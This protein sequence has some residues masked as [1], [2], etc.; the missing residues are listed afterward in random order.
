MIEQKWPC[1]HE[2]II[3]R[4]FGTSSHQQFDGGA[5]DE[6]VRCDART[7]VVMTMMLLSWCLPHKA[8]HS[9][10]PHNKGCF[11]PGTRPLPFWPGDVQLG[12]YKCMLSSNNEGNTCVAMVTC[13][14]STCLWVCEEHGLH[15]IAVRRRGSGMSVELV[16][17]SC[18]PGWPGESKPRK[19]IVK[20]VW[21]SGHMSCARLFALWTRGSHHKPEGRREMDCGDSQNTRARQARTQC[22]IKQNP[23]I[24][25][26]LI[27]FKDTTLCCHHILPYI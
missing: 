20:K 21:T 2:K 16:H 3:D 24:T 7:F 4:W 15:S 12:K 11:L 9:T 19:D 22:C 10:T 26:H 13:N 18:Q 5:A 17:S 6:C 27:F 1:F 23:F 8:G 25:N 14:L